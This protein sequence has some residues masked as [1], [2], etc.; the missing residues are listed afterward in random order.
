M[1]LIWN[2]LYISLCVQCRMTSHMGCLLGL[3][4]FAFV[5]TL[6]LVCVLNIISNTNTTYYYHQQYYYQYQP[7]I[8]TLIWQSYCLYWNI[9]SSLDNKFPCFWNHFELGLWSVNWDA[10]RQKEL[11]PQTVSERNQALMNQTDN[12]NKEKQICII[13]LED[14]PLY[15]NSLIKE[16]VDQQN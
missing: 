7:F 13:N 16:I 14:N 4:D 1:S 9:L 8:Q 5:F 11:K 15:L 12:L 3:S 2:L 10:S 6:A